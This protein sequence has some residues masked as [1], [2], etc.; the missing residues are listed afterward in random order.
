M[1]QIPQMVDLPTGQTI[2]SR[3]RA[4]SSSRL[5]IFCQSGQKAVSALRYNTRTQPQ[6]KQQPIT[7]WIRLCIYIY[8]YPF[9]RQDFQT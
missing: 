9:L 1:V 4:L 7:G 3:L 6:R 8:L 5:C 2:D